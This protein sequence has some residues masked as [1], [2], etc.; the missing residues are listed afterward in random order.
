MSVLQLFTDKE[1]VNLALNTAGV[2]RIPFTKFNNCISDMIEVYTRNILSF[3]EHYS[4]KQALKNISL[5]DMPVKNTSLYIF[6]KNNFKMFLQMLSLENVSTDS[7]E[8]HTLKS[9]VLYSAEIQKP[10]LAGCPIFTSNNIKDFEQI[11]N[12]E[13]A[14]RFSKEHMYIVETTSKI[15]QWGKFKSNIT[16]YLL[17]IP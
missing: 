13:Y 6:R 10:S 11:E 16:E 8:S 14:L 4:V 2:V 5:C 7:G 12:T 1:A 3:T 9:E 15:E 17:Y